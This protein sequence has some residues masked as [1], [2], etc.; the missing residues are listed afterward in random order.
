MPPVI[1]LPESFMRKYGII[2]V[3]RN[4]TGGQKYVFICKTISHGITAI[5]ML[6]GT[7]DSRAKRE[8][9]F[10]KRYTDIQ[11]IPKLLAVIEHEGDCYLLEEFITGKTLS[12]I[13]SEY[14]DNDDMIIRLIYDIC[15]IM[16]PLWMQN[17]V[18]RDLKPENI[19]IQLD[20]SPVVID[21]GIYKNPEDSS[22][23]ESNF[24][25]NSFPFAAPEQLIPNK[26]LISYRTDFFSLG[27]IAYYLKYGKF[28]FGQ[29][30]DDIIK[31]FSTNDLSCTFSAGCRIKNYCESV[32]N[33]D[34]SQR[35]RNIELLLRNFKV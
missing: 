24:Q 6:R 2:E 27:V 20:K 28:P 16:T 29:T 21:F 5:K 10:Y 9:E 18:H 7:L 8:I 1:S 22:I 30:R 26:A 33:S 11:G 17:I 32:F 25:P 4:F 13:S 14:F 31:K 12:S 3:L 34:V 23:T 19:I 35:P 15:D